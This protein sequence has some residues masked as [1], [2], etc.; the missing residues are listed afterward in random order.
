MADWLFPEID[1]FQ[2]INS[3]NITVGI[4]KENKFLENTIILLVLI[5][6]KK[7]HITSIGIKL[8]MRTYYG[9]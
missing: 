6:A 8:Y 2:Y 3:E 5:N 4:Y 7:P 9:S 1:L